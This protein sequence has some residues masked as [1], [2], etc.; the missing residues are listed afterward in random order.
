MYL[1]QLYSSGI[2]RISLPHAVRNAKARSNYMRLTK[3][4][5]ERI[6]DYTMSALGMYAP[7]LF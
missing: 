1:L 4:P 6:I 7:V 3:N 5:D 2:R